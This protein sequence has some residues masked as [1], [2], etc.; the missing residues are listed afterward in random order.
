MNLFADD[1]K[2]SK[3]LVS[4]DD[5][6]QLQL[7]LNETVNWSKEWLLSLNINKCVALNL[8]MIDSP[9]NDYCI[10]TDSGNYKLQNVKLTK[11]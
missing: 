7:A 10:D 6:T 9:N 5:K 8:K 11:I 1:A 4:L 3:T 2:M